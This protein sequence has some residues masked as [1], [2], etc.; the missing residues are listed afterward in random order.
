MKI[1][2]RAG[3]EKKTCINRLFGLFFLFIINLSALYLIYLYI[4]VAC[5]IKVDNI[6]HLPYEASGMQLFYYFISLPFFIIL[7]FVSQ[8]HSYYFNLRQS[9]FPWLIMIWLFYFILISYADEIVHF[10]KGNNLV[11]YGSLIISFFSICYLAYLT[12]CQ[13]SG[14]GGSYTTNIKTNKS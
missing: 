11:Y 2:C 12:I 4:S 14:L 9:L 7:S 5:S 8:L 13:L 3:Y 1:Y 10:L 6:F